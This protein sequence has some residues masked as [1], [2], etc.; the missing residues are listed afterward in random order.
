VLHLE[1]ERALVLDYKTNLLGELNPAEVVDDEYRV[2]RLVYALVCFR[3]GADDVE[4]VYQFLERSDETVS[5]S[6]TRADVSGLEQE[7]SAAVA[8]IRSG[9]FEPN[10]SEFTCR[11]CPALDVVCAGPRLPG[12]GQ[13][14]A[15][16]LAT[17]DAS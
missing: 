14:V 1:G 9:V 17:V 8:R 7:L 15:R 5:A 10:P 6:F 12:R 3:A 16:E 2:Q 4:V 11:G 13:R